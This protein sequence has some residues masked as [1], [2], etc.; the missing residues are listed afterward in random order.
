MPEVTQS[1]LFVPHLHSVLIAVK[2]ASA[3]AFVMMAAATHPEAQAAVQA[4]LDAVAGTD[5]RT[6]Y[7]HLPG[8]MTLNMVLPVPTFDDES[9]LP[10]VTAFYLEAYRWRPVSYGGKRTYL[11]F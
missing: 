7:P 9:L 8:G 5:R 10:L 3:I 6:S 1:V 11:H 4:Q 2:S